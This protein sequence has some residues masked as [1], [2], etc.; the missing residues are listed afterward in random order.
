MK[1]IYL[2][3]NATTPLHPEVLDA[4][5]PFLREKFGNPS[6]IHS[7]GREAKVAVDEAREF[8][9][10]ALDAEPAEIFFTSG[11]TESD[12]LAMKG[13]AYLNRKRGNHIITSK[14]EHHAVLQTC[15]FLE[16]E[17]FEVTYVSVDHT[18]MVDPSDVAEA[19]TDKTILVTIMH[20]NNEVGTLQPITEI[21]AMCKEKEIPFHTD[22]VQSFGK[23]PI[24]VNDMNIDLLSL[25]SHKLYG[26]KG[27]GSLYI[28]KGIRIMPIT[29]GGHHERNIRAGTENVAGIIGLGKTTQIALEVMKTEAQELTELRD[30]LYEKLKE[31]IEHVNLNGHPLQRLPGTLNLSFAGVEGE[32]IVLSLDL[33]GVAVSSG[34]ACTSGSLEPSYVLSAMGLSPELAQGSVRFSL[35][36]DTTPEN[37]EYVVE[38]LPEI[39]Q[40]LRVMSP[41]EVT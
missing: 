22:A 35:G 34:S 12:N 28:R 23:I 3:H 26:P 17:N 30:S 6:S 13:V 11:G 5:M 33:K 21:G 9:A 24:N 7:F 31:K 36:R 32:S 1:Q 41:M 29:H 2:D 37:V 19:I 10:Q 18:G 20:A 15:Q 4:M 38:L 14:V 40:R 25:S 39:V 8:V 27:I 16:K